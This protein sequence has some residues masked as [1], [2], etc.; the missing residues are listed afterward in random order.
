MKQRSTALLRIGRLTAALAAMLF[1]AAVPSGAQAYVLTGPHILELTA[2]AMGP[3]ASLAVDEKLLVYPPLQERPATVLDETALYVMPLRFRSVTVVDGRLTYGEDL[4]DHYQRLLRSRTRSQLMHTLNRLGIET[5]VS[6]LGRVDS[7]VVYVVGAHYPDETV[8]QLAVDKETF[9][10]L[11]LLLVEG[12]PTAG[13]MRLGIFYNAWRITSPMTSSSVTMISSN[14]LSPS[15]HLL[16]Q[17]PPGQGD[18]RHPPERQ[19]CHRPAAAR[20]RGAGRIHPTAGRRRRITG[21]E[22]RSGGGRAAGRTELSEK[23]RVAGFTGRRNMVQAV[24]TR[25]HD[26]GRSIRG[27]GFHGTDA[28][29]FQPAGAQF[30]FTRTNSNNRGKY[31]V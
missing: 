19:S 3:I 31:G 22:T 26:R 7:R 4:F 30:R 17:R 24:A 21:A 20:H 13:G 23:I 27:I 25:H 9:L 12:D 11:R 5:A 10:P 14:I 2:E 18:P 8:I 15:D 28:R 6:S 1:L 29:S 16:R